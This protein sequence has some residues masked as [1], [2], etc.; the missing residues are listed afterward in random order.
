MAH[1]L[2]RVALTGGIATGKSHCLQAFA[3]LGV[4]TI[5]ADRLARGA[6]APG[7]TGLA[8]V[9]RR[10]GPGMLAADGTLN[11]EALGA[12][13]FRD[14]GARRD[15]E[16]IVH[17]I[18]YGL[19]RVWFEGP[20]RGT[21]GAAPPAFAIAEVPL[22][23]ETERAGDFDRVVVATCDRATQKHRAMARDGATEAEVES[24]IGAQLRIED[25]AKRADYVIDTNG[26]IEETDRQIVAVWERLRAE[27]LAA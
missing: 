13:V 3:Q 19:I 15:L 24:R 9:V 22:L 14:P 18:V 5:D 16:A 12:L 8:E 27:A 17:P 26:T 21:P 10:F 25:K 2:F 6:V 4:P 20:W 1:R 23:Y 7:T 11:R